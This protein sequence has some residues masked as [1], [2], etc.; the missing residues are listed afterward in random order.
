MIINKY[1]ET[2]EDLPEYIE[3]SMTELALGTVATLTRNLTS[4]FYTKNMI[5]TINLLLSDDFVN[6]RKPEYV[7]SAALSRGLFKITPL[8]GGLRYLLIE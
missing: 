1:L 5:E 8:S 2:N 4:K 3:S 6:A 7:F